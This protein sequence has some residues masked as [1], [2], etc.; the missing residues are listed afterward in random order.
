MGKR[1]KKETE[2]QR[3]KGQKP[4][5]PPLWD[6]DRTV[7]LLFHGHVPPFTYMFFILSTCVESQGEQT[8]GSIVSEAVLLQCL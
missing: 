3:R 1:R 8:W 6:G 5:F 2:A 4:T 7:L